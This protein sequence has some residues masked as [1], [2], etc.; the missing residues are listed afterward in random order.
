[1]KKIM[2][3]ITG[4]VIGF[5]VGALVFGGVL[6]AVAAAAISASDI[7]FTTSKNANVATVK[8]AVD[9]LY[10]KADKYEKLLDYSK[11]ENSGITYKY[12][13]TVQSEVAYN[14]ELSG[15][16][17]TNSG[18]NN[19]DVYLRTTYINGTPTGHSACLKYNDREFCIEPNYWACPINTE[20]DDCGLKTK[21]KLQAA[22]EAALGTSA[23]DF[24]SDSD[25]ATFSFGYGDC[26]ARSDGYVECHSS[27]M[28][29]DASG[30][31]SD[32]SAY[33]DRF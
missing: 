27:T 33:F 1:M 24:Y 13:N 12:S 9:D 19:I 26:F 22:I 30:V 5:M 31:D 15:A 32:G 2:K 11:V 16:V 29:H 18:F 20:T 28:T 10:L 8:D 14:A 7:A 21:A 17:A 23:L 3:V 4:N 6:G 25:D